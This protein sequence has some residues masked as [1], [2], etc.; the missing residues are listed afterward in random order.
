MICEGLFNNVVKKK[1]QFALVKEKDKLLMVSMGQLIS[2]LNKP[3]RQ[4]SILWTPLNIFL[5]PISLRYWNN[6]QSDFQA[7]HY[8]KNK[9]AGNLM[10]YLSHVG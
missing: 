4:L 8:W 1:I 9:F 3:A 10:I 6:L 2:L 5:V 7:G